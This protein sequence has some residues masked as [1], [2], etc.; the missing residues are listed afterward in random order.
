[1]PLSN[2]EMLI[3]YIKNKD[4]DF[5][6]WD[7]CIAASL[8]S[9]IYALSWYLNSMAENWDALI[10]GDYEIVMPL[11]WKKKY[12]LKYIYH[13]PFTQQLGIF[14]KGVHVNVGPKDF[15]DA[16]PSSF[17][18]VDYFQ[19]QN[20]FSDSISN[21]VRRKTNL[22]IDLKSGYDALKS[23]YVGSL[24]RNL[25][26]AEASGCIIAERDASYIPLLI[27]FYTEAYGKFYQQFDA[28]VFERLNKLLSFAMQNNHAKI[29][30]TQLADDKIVAIALFFIDNHRI[31]Y[32]IGAPNEAGKQA[33]AM[34]FLFDLVI[35]KYCGQ[36]LIF[37]FEGSEI[38]SVATF[39]KKFGAE[40][41]HYYQSKYYNFFGIKR[42]AL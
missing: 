24:T 38:P 17:V 42:S 36:N 2:S 31:Y 12:G 16:I 8:N 39:Y 30:T 33:K 15:F 23:K 35:K 20:S 29:F 4:I 5:K 32:L 13:A 14:S 34:P 11:P 27:D 25:K 10:Y 19:S 26:S 3:R 37:D 40:T 21:C 18:I 6:K 7:A 9:R 41:E 28:K 22:I 1:M